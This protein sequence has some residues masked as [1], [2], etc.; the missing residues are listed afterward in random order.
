M[1]KVRQQLGCLASMDEEHEP[2]TGHW[3][4]RDVGQPGK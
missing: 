1:E 3:C 4:T 2:E